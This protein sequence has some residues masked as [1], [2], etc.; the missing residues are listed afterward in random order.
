GAAEGVRGDLQIYTLQIPVAEDL[1]SVALPDS[2]R[3][4]QFLRVDRPTGGE[5]F[6][7][8]VQVHHLVLDLEAVPEPLQL[9]QAPV[10]R[11]LPPLEAGRDLLAGVRALGAPAGGLALRALA[12][13]HPRPGRPAP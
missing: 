1:D 10:D 6:R 3:T 2:A 9:R 12:A 8:P 5:Q 4:D 13:T 7:Q 11:R